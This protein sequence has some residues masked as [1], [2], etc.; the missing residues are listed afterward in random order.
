MTTRY[1]HAPTATAYITLDIDEHSEFITDQLEL[2]FAD[3]PYDRPDDISLNVIADGPHKGQLVVKFK[4][5]I[6][7]PE[8]YG[9]KVLKTQNLRPKYK[10]Q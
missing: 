6:K 4:L 8:S 1:Y 10:S 2:F 7:K 9:F 5:D 3:E